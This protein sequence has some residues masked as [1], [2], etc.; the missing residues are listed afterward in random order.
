[1]RLNCLSRQPEIILDSP[2]F[3]SRSSVF[4]D[5]SEPK[6]HDYGQGEAGKGSTSS[7]FQNI[8]S[9]VAAHSSS[10][11]IEKGDSAAIT[12]EN[13]SREAPSPSSGTVRRSGFVVDVLM[14]KVF[15]SCCPFVISSI[16]SFLSP[17]LNLVQ[18]VIS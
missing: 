14:D 13:M 2:Y 9:P 12:S 8:A 1:M 11:E 6:G 18:C 10:L 4:E 7:G 16:Y 17:M 3:E 15:T 5:P